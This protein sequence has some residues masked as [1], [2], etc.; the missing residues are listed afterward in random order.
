M[1]VL[2]FNFDVLSAEKMKA[3]PENLKINTKI[4]VDEIKELKNEV[5]KTK[6]GL[7]QVS[8]A[9]II[10]YEPGFAEVK[11]KGNVLLSIEDKLAKEILKDWKKKK[12]PDGFKVTLF[13]IIL[14]KATIKALELEDEINLPL[15]MPLPSLRQGSR[16][17]NEK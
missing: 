11:L 10:S 5:L 4:D 12:M 2:G 14:R 15:H 8:F 7:I 3:R 17:E 16:Q 6:E 13:N 1:K 9:H